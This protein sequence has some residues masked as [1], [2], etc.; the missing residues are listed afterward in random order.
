MSGVLKQRHGGLCC[1]CRNARTGAYFIS[2]GCFHGQRT[3]MFKQGWQKQ[4]QQQ[5]LLPL[6]GN[7]DSACFDQLRTRSVKQGTSSSQPNLSPPEK[8]VCAHALFF[9]G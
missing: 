9:F 5:K 7:P 3:L 6:G 1:A 4:K 8:R 2:Q